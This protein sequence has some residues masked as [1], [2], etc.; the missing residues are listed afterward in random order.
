[1]GT[2][3]YLAG[4]LPFDNPEPLLRVIAATLFT[5]GGWFLYLS[6]AIMINQYFFTHEKEE[7][8]LPLPTS[9][10]QAS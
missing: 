5:F 6:A 3:F 1:V 10:E 2:I 4:A 9:S 8:V 7:G